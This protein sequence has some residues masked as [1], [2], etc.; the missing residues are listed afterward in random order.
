MKNFIP[1]T[2]YVT[3]QHFSE[4]FFRFPLMKLWDIFVHSQ[5]FLRTATLFS[6]CYANYM[7]IIVCTPSFCWGGWGEVEP[8][9]KFSNRW[10]LTGTQL[11]EGGCWKGGVTFF[12][13]VAI[14]QTKKKNKLKSEMF[15]DK[16]IYKQKYF[17]LS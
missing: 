7:I 2:F 15:N 13:R 4:M 1:F 6:H 12:R 16:K 11:W 3:L 8:L 9:T 14:L 5:I 10:A 17:S